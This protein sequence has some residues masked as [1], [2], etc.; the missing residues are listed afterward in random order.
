MSKRVIRGAIALS[1][2]L[3]GAVPV[4]AGVATPAAAATSASAAGASESVIVV[5]KHQY[6]Y[7]ETSAGITQRVAAADTAQAPVVAS[8]RSSHASKVTQL[9]LIDAVTATVTPV[10]K[11]ALADNANV[12]EVVPNAVIKGPAPI[13][14][15][16]LKSA[17]AAALAPGTCPAPGKVQLDPEGVELVHAV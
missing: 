1:L 13:T 17:T 7:P 16:P 3:F 5:L 8:L 14:A 9:H 15:T 4:V 6:S 2:G 12:A 11:A 10:E